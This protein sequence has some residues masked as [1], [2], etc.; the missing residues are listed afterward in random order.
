M[1][2]LTQFW[3]SLSL[4]LLV[5]FQP[6]SAEAKD[7]TKTVAAT[8]DGGFVMGNPKA[9]L[10]LVEYVSMSCPHCADF[11]AEAH[12]KLL[13]DY[14][15]PGK[16]SYEIRNLVRDPFDITAALVS[17]CGGPERFFALTHRLL[18]AQGEWIGKLSALPQSELDALQLLPPEQQYRSIAVHGGFGGYAGAEGLDAAAMEACLIDPAGNEQLMKLYQS[19]MDL[20]IRGVPAFVLNGTLIE[21]ASWAAL[22]P[23]LLAAK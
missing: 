7:W 17:R 8:P 11:D 23:Q 12:S 19:A 14:V 13:N 18:A 6:I 21:G 5:A 15:K 2:H 1:Q 4:L 16:L 10:R 20:Q 22:E 3:L 9:K